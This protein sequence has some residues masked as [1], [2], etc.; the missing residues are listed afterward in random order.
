[1]VLLGHGRA[2]AVQVGAVEFDEP[3]AV[4]AVEVIVAGVAVFVL[5]D[6]P[7][8]QGEFADQARLDQFG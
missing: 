2:D 5:E 7:C 4:L 8:A 1:M 6:A 3:V